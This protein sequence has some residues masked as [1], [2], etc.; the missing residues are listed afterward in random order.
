MGKLAHLEFLQRKSSIL[1]L[2]DMKLSEINKGDFPE[3]II[4]SPLMIKNSD[5]SPVN[6]ILKIK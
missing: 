3:Q 4:I 2:E 5:G 1:I 6:C